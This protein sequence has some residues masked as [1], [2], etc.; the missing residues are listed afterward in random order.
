LNADIE[1]T[2]RTKALLNNIEITENN[3]IEE[4]RKILGE[5]FV[6]LLKMN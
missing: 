5:R 3:N 2:Q 4:R 6:F 1:E